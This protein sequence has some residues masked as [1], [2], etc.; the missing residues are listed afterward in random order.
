MKLL[1]NS[2]MKLNTVHVLDVVAA[3]YELS[4]NQGAVRQI[5]NVVDDSESTQGTISNILADIFNINVDYW[6][7]VLSNI[8]KVKLALINVK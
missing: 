8:T 6:G 3:A 7:T 2:T 5:Y 1:W 4:T